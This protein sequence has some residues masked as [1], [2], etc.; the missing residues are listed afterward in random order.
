VNGVAALAG[1]GQGLCEMDN[2]INI[3]NEDWFFF[4]FLTVFKLL[5]Q[6]NGNSVNDGDLFNF[7]ISV[8]GGPCDCLS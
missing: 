7:I 8:R 2:R 5:S 3:L 6:I 4:C 1:G